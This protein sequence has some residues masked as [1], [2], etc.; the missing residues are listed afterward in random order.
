MGTSGPAVADTPAGSPVFSR[1]VRWL[2]DV[3][4]GG[5]KLITDQGGL[6]KFGISQ[7]AYPNEDIANLTRERAEFLYRRDYWT[8]IRADT[9]PPQLALV[10]FDCTVNSGA[11]RAVKILQKCVRTKQDG[12]MGPITVRAST[13]FQP[14][15]ELV[16]HYLEQR[17]QFYEYLA[18][19]WPARH[20][21]SLHGWRMRLMRLALEAGRWTDPDRSAS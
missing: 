3:A 19:R 12:A 20:G 16:A 11:S 18:K 8:P 21:E 17:L 14:Q 9:L 5:D 10:V 6:T 1:S 13:L 4:E 15:L 7:D 2:I